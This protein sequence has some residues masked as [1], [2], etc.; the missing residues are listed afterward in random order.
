M[1]DDCFAGGLGITEKFV[2][3]S[4]KRDSGGKK[5]KKA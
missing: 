4:V 2:A 3:V 1:V 5:Q